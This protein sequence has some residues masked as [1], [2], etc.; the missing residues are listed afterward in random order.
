MAEAK[1]RRGP[2][3][4][5]TLEVVK[6]VSERVGRGMPLKLALAT[7]GNAKINEETWKKALKAHSNFPPIYEAA[8]GKFLDEAMRKLEEAEDLKYVCWLLERRHSDLFARPEPAAVVNVS[9]SVGIPADVIE[10]A[11]EL[12]GAKK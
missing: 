11:R 4:S 10:R 5:I 3:P 1:G 7:E 8:K 9:Q 12:A 2:K 6:R